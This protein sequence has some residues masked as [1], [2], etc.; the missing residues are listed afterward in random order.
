M[1]NFLDFS[2]AFKAR[3]YTPE[4]YEELLGEAIRKDAASWR[5]T[6]AKKDMFPSM[7]RATN[8]QAE[9]TAQVLAVI[10]S[11]KIPLTAIEI[12]KKCGLPRANMVRD[13]LLREI[14]LNNI[15]KGNKQLSAHRHTFMRREQDETNI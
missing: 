1:T 4:Y 13:A 7:F 5:N 6:C 10:D 15:V 2:K 12:A 14:G 11:S 9:R 8:V 3:T